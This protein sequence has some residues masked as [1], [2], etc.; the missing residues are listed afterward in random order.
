MNKR[1]QIEHELKDLNSGLDAQAGQ[2]PYSVPE[3]YFEGFA[4]SMLSRIQ[5]EGMTAAEEIARL[6]PVLAGIT[7]QMPFEVPADYFGLNLEGLKAFT[8][9]SED[10]LVLSF[11]D[12]EMPYEVPPGYFA[13]V[14]EQVLEKVSPRGKVVSMGGRKWMRLAVAAMIT[15]LITFSGIAYFNSR[16]SASKVPVTVALKKAST[17][18][19]KEFIK[20]TAVVIPD[21]QTPLTA[22]N[23]SSKNEKANLFGDVSDKELESFLK[24]VSTED[25]VLDF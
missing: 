10:S 13:N 1:N 2:N 19:L 21:E 24:Q 14:P 7:R 3:G 12:K 25:E 9:E 15:G 17:E 6:S 18:E 20:N 11:I 4:A 23:S 8:S 22:R 5:T 16:S